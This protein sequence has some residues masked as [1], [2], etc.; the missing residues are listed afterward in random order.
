N[1][2]E[3]IDMIEEG[4]V[5]LDSLTEIGSLVQPIQA[6]DFVKDIRAEVSKS[7]F[8]PIFAGASYSSQ[9]DFPHDLEYIFDGII[10][11]QLNDEIVEDTLIKQLRIRKLESVLAISEWQQYEFTSEQGMVVFDPQEEMEKVKPEE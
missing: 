11:L 2:L 4:I 10:D 9:D 3:S 8:V 6:Y 1:C 7:R 5:L